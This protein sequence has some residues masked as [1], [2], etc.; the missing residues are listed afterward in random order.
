MQTKQMF[1]LLLAA[2][3]A[4]PSAALASGSYAARPPKPPA[5]KAGSVAKTDAT[6]YELGKRI[7][8]GK[9]KLGETTTTS[10]AQESRLRDLQARLPERE[11]KSANLSRLAGKL[12]PEQLDA[13][14]YYIQHR[15]PQK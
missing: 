5:G 13:L 11:Q 10:T 6:R 12:T 7:Y 1:P 14:E 8:N 15:F 9:L 4:L 3:V 2:A